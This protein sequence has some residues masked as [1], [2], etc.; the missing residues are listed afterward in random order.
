MIK[1]PDGKI[2]IFEVFEKEKGS[3]LT[4]EEIDNILEKIDLEKN[5][6]D[7]YVDAFGN[8]ISFAGIRTIKKE[9]TVIK[10]SD[11]QKN[12]I[13]KCAN[14]YEYFRKFYC[15]IITKNGIGRPEPREYQ[16]RLEKK[17]LTNK[18]TVILY[19]RQAGKT[20]TVS[21]YLL[22]KANFANKVTNIGIAGNNLKIATEILDLIKKIFLELPIWLQKGVK[23]WNRTFIELEGRIRIMTAACNGDAFRGFTIN[24]AFID[25]VAF[26]PKSRW[27]EFKDSVFPALEAL[28]EKQIILTSTPN[29]FNH[30]Y[31]YCY[32]AMQPKIEEID[33]EK[34]KNFALQIK[35][36]DKVKNYNLYEF[37]ANN[38]LVQIEN[39]EKI[40]F[41]NEIKNFNIENNKIKI[42]Y[43]Y[44]KNNFIFETVG[45]REVPRYNKDG[46]LKNPEDFKKEIIDKFGLLYFKQNYECEFLG[47]SETLINSESLKR[48]FE[49]V[50]EPV[51]INY[52]HHGIKIFEEPVE[53][54]HYI[55]GLDPKKEGTDGAGIQ[56]LDV[57]KMPFKQVASANLNESFLTMPGILFDLGNYYNQAMIVCENNIAESIPATLFYSYEYEGEVFIEKDKNGR[58]K[59]EFGV[60][61]TVKTKRLGLSL[62]K[63]LIEENQLVINDKETT[64]QLFHFIKNKKGSYE[65]EE[66]YH[67][68]L[69][70]SLVISLAPFF[71]F[72]SWDDFKGFVDYLRKTEEEQERLKEIEE[73]EFEQFLDLGF[74]SF[75]TEEPTGFT[76]ELWE[77]SN[78]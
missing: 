46:S 2:G 30:F 26:I 20:A 14:D 7:F 59:K 69:V 9:N 36:N 49:E 28:Q 74:S 25:E 10:I 42:T 33:L 8:Q 4:D 65:A 78:F 3:P 44:G 48:L 27:E 43:I 23:L 64:E 15:K 35:E 73:Q 55:I 70:M 34:A 45:W 57:T 62:L 66:G 18:D 63:K 11:I 47:S 37:I 53:G 24:I 32:L 39:F 60:R 67:D 5:D 72:K 56:I 40:F 58:P 68:D 31:E 22:W 71:D 75:E 77:E 12:E 19:S 41:K 50:K 1:N 51:K 13:I 16:K 21:T 38:K 52:I 54:H 29:G 76:E 17:L 6:E 61:T